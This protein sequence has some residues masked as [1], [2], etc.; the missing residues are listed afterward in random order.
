M[1]RMTGVHAASLG[2][3]TVNDELSRIRLALEI[4]VN[5]D[6]STEEAAEC[7]NEEE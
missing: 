5:Q 3:S 7:A 4:L 2:T 6:I 1:P